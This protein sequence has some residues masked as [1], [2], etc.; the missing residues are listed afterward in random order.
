[1][2]LTFRPLNGLDIGFSRTF[3]IGGEGRSSSPGTFWDAFIGDDNT[4]DPD[5]DHS[6]Q[7]GAIDIRYGFAIG[8]HTASV[9]TQMMGED[10]A[11][12]L[13]S[14]KSWMFGVDWTTAMAGM[15]QQWYLEATD[16]LADNL[17]GSGM[18][19]ITYEH[20]VYQTG[21]RYRGRNL[22][23]SIEADSQAVTLGMYNF[24]QQG[25]QLGLALTW[26]DLTGKDDTRV[27]NPDPDIRYS[28]PGRDQE[29]LVLS[30]SFQQPL[31]VGTLGLYT[32]LMDDEIELID[33]ERDQWSA[34]ASWTLSF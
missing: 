18:P 7:L 15:D 16:T 10:E 14:R 8:D 33:G 19:D 13:P 5:D 26:L 24:S 4:D 31:P 25:Q 34:A 23:T 1:M 21:Y 20:R 3:V 30:A 12:A 32:E 27:I 29:R 11:G 2:R 28:V 6:N 9:Y 22:A 17:T